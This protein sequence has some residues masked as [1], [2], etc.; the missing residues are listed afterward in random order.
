MLGFHPTV[1]QTLPVIKPHR[2]E[3]AVS[4]KLTC[5]GVAVNRR[6]DDVEKACWFHL[7]PKAT[8]VTV[9]GFPYV[10]CRVSLFFHEHQE[11]G[12]CNEMPEDKES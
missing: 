2:F 1:E 10:T 4:A 6:S 7:S 5:L 3:R 11:S 12:T 9:Q 8:C